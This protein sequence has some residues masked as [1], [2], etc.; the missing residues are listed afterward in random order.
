MALELFVWTMINCPQLNSDFVLL[1]PS[2]SLSFP[3]SSLSS[4][5]RRRSAPAFF[6]SLSG[7]LQVTRALA[8]AGALAHRKMSVLRNELNLCHATIYGTA[9]SCKTNLDLITLFHLIAK[10]SLRSVSSFP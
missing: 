9:E 6:Q 5:T 3:L 4:F 10:C 2:L 1:F 7:I 8:L